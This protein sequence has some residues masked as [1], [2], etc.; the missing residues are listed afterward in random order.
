MNKLELKDLVFQALIGASYVVL[1]LIFYGYSYGEIQFRI[2]EA[3]LILVF[4]NKKNAIG[5]IIGT[6]IANFIGDIGI[7]DALFGTLATS[8]TLYL[9]LL[10]K[11]IKPVALIFPVIINAIYVGFLLNVLYDLPLWLT[12]L[13]VSLGEAA[14]VYILG[15]PLYYA[16]YRNQ[17]F[18]QLFE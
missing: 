13:Q 10:F 15:L 14:V 6:F 16:L 2:S 8:I 4:F 9:M 7:I 12:M 5:L 11:K 18:T 17:S 3:L 1:T